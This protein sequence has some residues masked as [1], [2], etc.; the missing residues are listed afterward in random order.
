MIYYKL[1]TKNK[2]KWS[3]Q[4]APLSRCITILF[5]LYLQSNVMKAAMCL[6]IE[7]HLISLIL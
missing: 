2:H 4:N 3:L 1:E 6:P 5:N 7:L